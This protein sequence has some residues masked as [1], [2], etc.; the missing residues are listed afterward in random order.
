MLSWLIVIGILQLILPYGFIC[1]AMVKST[2]PSTRSVSV[3][4][5]F[6]ISDYRL[7]SEYLFSWSS[8]K[9]SHWLLSHGTSVVA[10]LIVKTCGRDVSQTGTRL[11]LVKDLTILTISWR[12]ILWSWTL[13]ST[14]VSQSHKSSTIL[15]VLFVKIISTF[16]GLIRLS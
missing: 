13:A 16:R 12:I 5:L 1:K 9:L 15:I 11:L 14:L 3:C 6:D 4:C 7:E 2:M 10:R 8:W